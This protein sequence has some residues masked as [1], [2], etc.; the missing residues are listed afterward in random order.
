MRMFVAVRPPE[1]V[2]ADLADYVEPRRDVDS[3]L[4]WSHPEQWHV[5][6][7]FLPS[8][9][10]RVLD[11]LVERLA[12]TATGRPPFELQ[13]AG[14]GAFPNP[15]RAKVLWAGVGGD[16]A[17][18]THLAGNLRSAAGRAGTHVDGGEFRPHVTLARIGRPLDVTRW[19]RVF[20]LYA[21]ASWQVTEVVL[22]HSRLGGGPA[23]YTEV[24]RFSLGRSTAEP[25]DR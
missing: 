11:D 4:R 25:A 5:T 2:L 19:L 21:S 6:L 22:F 13:L 14:A 9:T 1:P 12:E 20:D 10:D 3:P 7:A 24:K 15:G 8:V 17:A 18:L 23:R 16:T